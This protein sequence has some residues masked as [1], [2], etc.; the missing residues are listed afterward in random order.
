MKITA[1]CYRIENK[2]NGK[3]YIGMSANLLRREHDHFKGSRKGCKKLYAAFKKYG[4]NNFVFEVIFVQTYGTVEDL[5]EIEKQLIADNNSITNGYNILPASRGRGAYGEE[6][7]SYIRQIYASPELR[8]K[9]SQPGDKNP[10]FGRSRKGEKVGGAVTPLIGE[11][12]PMF[13]RDWRVGK[14]PEEIETHKKNSARIG[15]DNGCF[16][17]TFLWINKDGI[18]RRHEKN[19]AIPKGWNVGFDKTE[20]MQKSRCRM[21][22]CITTGAVYNSLTEASKDTGCS[23]SK[24]SLCCS[25]KRKKTG[26]LEWEYIEAGQPA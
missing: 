13:G 23:N 2:L 9:C 14:T 24:I 12:N 7:S 11:N 21:V 26:G 20:A 1:G 17:T 5:A 6:W 8:Q 19:E 25:G 4:I 16:G 22:L 10:M 3:T 15:K 18:Y